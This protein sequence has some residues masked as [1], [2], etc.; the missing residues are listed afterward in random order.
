MHAATDIDQLNPEQVRELAVRLQAE[1]RVKQ[2]LIDKLTHEM[3]IL[4][5]HKF[6]ATSEAYTGEQQRVLFESVEM[7]LEALTAEI[8]QLVPELAVDREKRQP[9]S[10]QGQMSRPSHK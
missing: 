1:I 6:A 9:I 4:K 8:D 3:A 2:A 10:F 7:D 5:R